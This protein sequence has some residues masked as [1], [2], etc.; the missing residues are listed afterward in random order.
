MLVTIC[1]V[2]TRYP[3][4]TLISPRVSRMQVDPHQLE[5]T[6][7]LHEASGYTQPRSVAAKKGA[8]AVPRSTTGQRLPCLNRY[9]SKSRCI[10]LC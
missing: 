2:R 5:R 1:C 8:M 6:S 4:G 7:P 3:D 9:A 10:G